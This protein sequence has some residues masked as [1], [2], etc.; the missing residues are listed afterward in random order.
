VEVIP[1]LGPFEVEPEPEK[2]ATY[3]IK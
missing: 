2:E 3:T 1:N